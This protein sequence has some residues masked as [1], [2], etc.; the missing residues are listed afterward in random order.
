[1]LWF[2]H[3]V[4]YKL[5]NV[6]IF[7]TQSAVLKTTLCE[8]APCLNIIIIIISYPQ[9]CLNPTH[10]TATFHKS[11]TLFKEGDVSTSPLG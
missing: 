5:L 8:I 3:M 4:I 1:M 7:F 2:Y 6:V 9:I 10:N 11:H